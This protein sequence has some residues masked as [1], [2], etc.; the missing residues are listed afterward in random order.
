MTTTD[1]QLGAALGAASNSSPSQ[2]GQRAPLGMALAA[3]EAAAV[4]DDQP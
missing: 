3:H 4:F 2:G 1:N